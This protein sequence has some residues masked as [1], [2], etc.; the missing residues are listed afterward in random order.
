[1]Q[2]ARP[3]VQGHAEEVAENSVNNEFKVSNGWLDRYIRRHQ[4]AFNEVC[5]E[6]GDVFEETVTVWT[7]RL[8]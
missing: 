3:T 2:I 4:I 1:L 6:G 5:G 7:T 8:S